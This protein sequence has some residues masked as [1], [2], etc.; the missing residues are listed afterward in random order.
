MRFFSLSTLKKLRDQC[1]SSG[2]ILGTFWNNFGEALTKIRKSSANFWETL[3]NKI[4]DVEMLW[5]LECWIILES[6][7]IQFREYCGTV[8]S[9]RTSSV[10]TLEKFRDNFGKALRKPRRLSKTIQKRCRITSEK[11]CAIFAELL[12][13]LR[14][15]SEIT[16]NML[17]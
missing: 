1:R 8:E 12:K 3:E 16:T 6:V 11:F 2:I 5:I 13:Q 7:P 14:Q 15:S 10:E 17:F 9:F 4:L